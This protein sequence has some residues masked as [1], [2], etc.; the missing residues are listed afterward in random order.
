MRFSSRMLLPGF[1]WLAL[2]TLA[3]ASLGC[4]GSATDSAPTA[5]PASSSS[6][7]ADSAESDTGQAVVDGTSAAITPADVQVIDEAGFAEFMTNHRGKVIF[8]DFWATWCPN[9]L[10]QFP[11]T[12][13]LH[14]KYADQGLVVVSVSFDEGDAATLDQVAEFLTRQRAHFPAFISKYGLDDES[15][16][17]FG[18]DDNLP[19][20]QL[21]GRDGELLEKFIFSDPA[22]AA[23]TPEQIDARVAEALK[24]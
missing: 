3:L 4:S 18:I 12:V 6:N 8:I 2:G 24:P 5:T 16:A 20:Y 13:E 9:C 10:D 7:T 23:P 14:E 21:Y 15:Y 19:H 17:M 22:Q 1:L 11:H